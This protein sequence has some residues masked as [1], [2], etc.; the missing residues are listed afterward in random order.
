M[1][2]VSPRPGGRVLL[3]RAGLVALGGT[4]G[5]AARAAL[6]TAAPAA[7]GA[8]PWTTFGINVAGSF[9]LG[10]LLEGL[11]RRG[12]D[13]GR[14]RAV[15]LLVGTGALGGFTTYSTFAAETEQLL[16]GGAVL[17]GAGYAVA[18][19]ASG[20]GSAVVGILVARRQSGS[21]PR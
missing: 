6:E 20:V 17:L 4:V 1:G 8:V 5:T 2:T 21:G 12:Q 15:R 9:L 18:S 11:V 19:V 16:S 10:M 13:E 7:P 14:R 3:S